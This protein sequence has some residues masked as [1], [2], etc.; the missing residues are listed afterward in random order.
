[1]PIPLFGKLV[2]GTGLPYAD[3]RF[4]E[5]DVSSFA[6]NLDANVTNVQLLA[7]AVDALSTS[8]GSGQDLLLSVV[9]HSATTGT[10]NYGGE[11][12]D[13]LHILGGAVSG[14][15]ALNGSTFADGKVFVVING[16]SANIEFDVSAVAQ[17]FPS[18]ISSDPQAFDML[19][20]RGYMFWV[21]SNIIY[22]IG[23]I[24]LS[25][26][27]AGSSDHPVTLTRDTPTLSA[28]AAIAAA[29]TNANS[30]LW[31]VASDQ[32]A[33]TESAV[34]GT[35]MIRAL[36]SGL[37]DANN[38][39]ISTTAVAKSGVVL[40]AGTVVRVFSST[41]LRVVSTP[42]VMEAAMRYPDRGVP[43]SPLDLRNEGSYNTYRNRTA[44]VTDAASTS[45]GVYE[46][47]LPSLQNSEALAY[48]N[49]NDVFG[50]RNDRTDGV[51]VQVRTFQVGTEFSG[52]QNRINL[53]AGEVLY[54][55]PT[56]TGATWTIL[57][58]GQASDLNTEVIN[59]NHDWYRDAE[60]A[61]AA[62]NSVRLHHR[63]EIVD[64]D[65]RN[66]VLSATSQNN[67][68]TFRL[69]K[70]DIEDDIAW[71]NFWSSHDSNVPPLQTI[72]IDALRDSVA[73]AITYITNNISNGFDF[74][75]DDPAA[76]NSVAYITYISGDTV[77]I[78]VTQP[79]ESHIVVGDVLSIS[80]SSVTANNGDWAITS[81]YSDR[82]AFNITIPGASGANNTGQSGVI[83]R[84]L[85][86]DAVLV[87]H[88]LRQVNID[89]YHDSARTSPLTSLLPQWVDLTMPGSGYSFLAVAYNNSLHITQSDQYL[90]GRDATFY[91]VHSGSRKDVHLLYNGDPNNGGATEPD[92]NL[93]R[94]IPTQYAEV[95]IQT[96]AAANFIIP[97]QSQNIPVGETR[98]IRI[99]SDADNDGNDVTL[100]VGSSG[101]LGWFEYFEGDIPLFSLQ[102]GA[103]IDVEGYNDGNLHGWRIASAF[104]K[105]IN[106]TTIYAT[107][108]QAFAGEIPIEVISQVI[109]VQSED[110]SYVFLNS[111]NNKFALNTALEYKI[112]AQIDVLFNGTEG[113]GLLFV[114]VELIPVLTRSATDTDLP[115]Y[116]DRASLLFSRNGLT[117]NSAPKFQR[118]LKVDFTWQAQQADQIGLELRFGTFPQGDVTQLQI[119]NFRY[120]VTV[121]G[122]LD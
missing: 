11:F 35:I 51:E 12:A 54:V 65:L 10:Q 82:L 105:V 42:T 80:S 107:A 120:T 31:I 87:A 109:L 55:T 86:A 24:D 114:P 6:N 57:Q 14:F 58:R 29:S 3:A 38:A 59:I 91:K 102:P 8:G 74:V 77:K 53:A 73:T 116:A 97:L 113:T 84:T 52:L 115:Q 88:D 32:I 98:T 72:S 30:G 66:H 70:R 67:P 79:L 37:L 69:Y 41:D 94:Y 33:A 1:M 17:S 16:S 95:H 45:T 106:S 78:G 61:T 118:T 121:Q 103:Y 89:L 108:T 18:Y 7:Q 23:D 36:S 46:V 26:S 27:A 2:S 5:L 101:I 60:D 93:N 122:R 111:I 75:L 22:L 13:R 100:R 34:D 110:P 25:P 85:Y 68:L 39:E 48:L 44:V 92:F 71:I 15:D 83:N 76:F 43:D 117:G 96:Q 50:F 19:A 64:G 119:Q 4:V 63:Q 62:D 99:Y 49:R 47:R 20:G 21:K 56:A 112:E 28:L 90:Q 81:I 40:Q 104:Q 9:T